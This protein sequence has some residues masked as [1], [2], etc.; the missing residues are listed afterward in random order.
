MAPLIHLVCLRFARA[1]HVEADGH[2]ATLLGLAVVM[3]E[4]GIGRP[5]SPLSSPSTA[6][7][8]EELVAAADSPFNF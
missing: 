1:A 3:N 2:P 7:G 6:Q 5:L 4:T 8:L